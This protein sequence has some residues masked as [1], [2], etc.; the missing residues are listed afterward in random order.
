MFGYPAKFNS[1]MEL[2]VMKARGSAV[3]GNR[4]RQRHITLMRRLSTCVIYSWTNVSFWDIRLYKVPWP[5]NRD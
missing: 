1:G 5:W 4:A 2:T 3:A